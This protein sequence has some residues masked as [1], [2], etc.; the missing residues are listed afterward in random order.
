MLSQLSTSNFYDS[1]RYLGSMAVDTWIDI[2]HFAEMYEHKPDRPAE[3][4][5]HIMYSS[6]AS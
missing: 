4:Q 6:A 2:F 3:L 1:K 5:S